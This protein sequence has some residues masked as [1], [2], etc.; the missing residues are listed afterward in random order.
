MKKIAIISSA[1][2]CVLLSGC[3][4][5]SEYQKLENRVTALETQVS[6]QNSISSEA[7]GINKATDVKENEA[8]SQ[9]IEE[10]VENKEGSVEEQNADGTTEKQAD[11]F[12]YYVDS[13]SS[14]EI[15]EECMRLFKIVPAEGQSLEEYLH[16]FSVQPVNTPS[17][18][19]NTSMDNL[20]LEYANV[21]STYPPILAD[22]DAIIKV[23]LHGVQAEMDGNIGYLYHNVT[24]DIDLD[25]VEYQKAASVYD[26]LYEVLTPAYYEILDSHEGTSWW[27]KGRSEQYGLFDIISLY[28]YDNGFRLHVSN[29][30][31]P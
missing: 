27:A 30:I 26:E 3:V 9:K 1:L 19:T 6:Q 15:V 4:S 23:T 7:G 8:D 10:N 16:S 13:L 21:E 20:V 29:T 5:D 2:A 28:K 14:H 11:S 17:L 18:P 24:M 22:R 31:Y 12:V 25:I